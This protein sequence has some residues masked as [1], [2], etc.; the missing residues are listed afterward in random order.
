VVDDPPAGTTPAVT[1]LP[2]IPHLSSPG[3]VPG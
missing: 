3:P 1:R 2:R